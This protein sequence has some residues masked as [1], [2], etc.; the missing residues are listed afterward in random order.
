MSTEHL[1]TL[2]QSIPRIGK[3]LLQ[4]EPTYHLDSVAQVDAAFIE[5]HGIRVVLWDVDGTLMGY[6]ATDV[7]PIFAHVRVMF[8]DGPGQHAILSNCDE[9]RF[10][11]L[12]EIFPEVP[13]IRGYVSG[14]GTVLR[15]RLGT[16]DTHSTADVARILS[17]GGKQI[18]KP[19]AALVHYGMRLLDENDPQTVLMV[20][21]QY[22]TDVA[23]ANL[24]G[25]QS[26]KV[27]TFRRDTFPRSI[28][29]SQR[30]ELMLY[31]LL[32]GRG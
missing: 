10:L 17:S 24:A 28:R 11:A 8:R 31:R 20:G 14:D 21:D 22:L 19:S 16:T 7:D 15:Y 9:T 12:G 18:R 25:V 29:T 23:S 30:I 2:R 13:L 4:L 27:R 3:L 26:V 6:H 32:Y 1:A 5:Q